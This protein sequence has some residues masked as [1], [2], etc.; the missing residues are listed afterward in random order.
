[1][2]PVTFSG[3]T[4]VEE[5]FTIILHMKDWVLESFGA[6]DGGDVELGSVSVHGI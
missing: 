1:M 6:G 5:V 2:I 3:L 4:V